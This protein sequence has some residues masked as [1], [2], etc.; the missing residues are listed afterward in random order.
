MFFNARRVKHRRFQCFVA[1]ETRRQRV[2]GCRTIRTPVGNMTRRYQRHS[3]LGAIKSDKVLRRRQIVLAAE[4]ATTP[5]SGES[6]SNRPKRT[7]RKYGNK[8]RH[9]E[10]NQS[11]S[12]NKRLTKRPFPEHPRKYARH[13]QQKYYLLT[14]WLRHTLLR[15]DRT[16]RQGLCAC[17]HSV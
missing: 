12:C 9:G 15:T 14:L 17:L 6:S 11:D 7:S 3:R 2:G 13:V 10:T 16:I 1:S 8:T 5:A 4:R